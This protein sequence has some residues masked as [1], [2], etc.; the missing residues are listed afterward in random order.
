MNSYQKFSCIY[1]GQHIECNVDFAGRQ[2]H[3]PSCRQNLTVPPP[4]LGT[5]AHT[6]PAGDFTWDTIVP[7]PRVVTPFGN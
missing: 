5:N 1:C 3:C 6:I 4:G 7:D 2:F